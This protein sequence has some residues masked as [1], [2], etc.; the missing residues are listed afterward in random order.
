MI[1]YHSVNKVTGETQGFRVHGTGKGT[2]TIT[3]AYN[4]ELGCVRRTTVRLGTARRPLTRWVAQLTAGPNASVS[5]I[6]LR[7]FRT[8][9]A[10]AEALAAAVD[11]LGPWPPTENAPTQAATATAPTGWS[12]SYRDAADSRLMVMVPVDE[13]LLGRPGIAAV[14]LDLAR[15]AAGKAG[16]PLAD[17]EEVSREPLF[18]GSSAIAVKFRCTE[19]TK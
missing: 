18:V 19:A 1:T 15:E 2:A 4:R 12:A 8:R 17:L 9:L 10:A 5:L 14:I 16:M 11:D 3:D 6:S 7:A 13:A